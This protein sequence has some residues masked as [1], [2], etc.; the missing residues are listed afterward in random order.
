[1]KDVPALVYNAS[2]INLRRDNEDCIH[3]R[4]VEIWSLPIFQAD[5]GAPYKVQIY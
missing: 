3:L 5:M 4:T 1:M 2:R